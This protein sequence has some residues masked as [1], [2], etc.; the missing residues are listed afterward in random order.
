[1]NATVATSSAELVISVLHKVGQGV[2]IRDDRRLADIFGQAAQ[3]YPSF[4]RFSTHPLYFDCPLLAETL[5][6]LDMGGTIE[7][8][9]AQSQYYQATQLTLGDQGKNIYSQL[10][11]EERNAVDEVAGK[12]KNAFT[13]GAGTAKSC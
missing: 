4:K 11:E 12:I 10:S 2:R 7:R 8:F 3:K 1:M 9:N 6:L 13:S 5:H